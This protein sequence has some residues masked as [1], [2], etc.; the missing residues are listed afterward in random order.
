MI[1]HKNARRLCFIFGGGVGGGE[2]ARKGPFMATKWAQN[3]V[4]FSR[5]RPIVAYSVG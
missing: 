5:V 3:G 1:P 2:S 4:I